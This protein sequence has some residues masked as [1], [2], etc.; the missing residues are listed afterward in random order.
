[1]NNIKTPDYVIQLARDMRNNMTD[2]EKSLWSRLRRKQ[3]CGLKF[4]SQHPIFRYILDFYCHEK[5]LAIEIDGNN[6]KERRDYD[7]YRDEFMHSLG[8]KTVR[9][10]NQEV[11]RDVDS[12]MQKIRNEI[13]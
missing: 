10:R 11:L 13:A 6:H 3:L 8:I 7:E 1:M 12:V 2:A 9:I 4:R 5:R